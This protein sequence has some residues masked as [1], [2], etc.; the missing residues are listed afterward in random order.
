VQLFLLQ[1]ES[2][3][4]ELVHL[5]FSVVTLLCLYH[6]MSTKYKQEAGKLAA[7]KKRRDIHKIWA[8]YKDKPRKEAVANFRLKTG[9]TV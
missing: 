7:T 3:D 6:K 1:R 9:Q 5:Q 4:L 8:E 2:H